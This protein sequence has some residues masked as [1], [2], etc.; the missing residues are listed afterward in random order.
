MFK[1]P[2]SLFIT[3]THPSDQKRKA[4]KRAVS[5]FVSKS[6]RP[7]S[8]KIVFEKSHYRPFLQ[9]QPSPSPPSAAADGV[10]K[11]SRP[12]VHRAHSENP[13]R[14][15]ALDGA[16]DLHSLSETTAQ[17]SPASS[18][19]GGSLF[20]PEEEKLVD[21]L[22]ARF[23]LALNTERSRYER[24]LLVALD[25]AECYNAV[26]AQAYYRIDGDGFGNPHWRA[27]Y[28]RGEAMKL[29]REKMELRR[30]ADYAIFTAVMLLSVEYAHTDYTAW[31]LH[32]KALER[33]VADKGGLQ[34]IEATLRDEMLRNEFFLQVLVK[35]RVQVCS[36]SGG[37]T[38]RVQDVQPVDD[39]VLAGLPV[40]FMALALRMAL[41][42]SAAHFIGGFLTY[43]A[44]VG[45][46]RQ[47][48][49]QY[50]SYELSAPGVSQDEMEKILNLVDARQSRYVEHQACLALLVYIFN[51]HNQEAPEA[52]YLSILDDAATEMITIKSSGP[53]GS[54]ACLFWSIATIGAAAAESPW[55]LDMPFMGHIIL[56]MAVG[57]EHTNE[58]RQMLRSYY[59]YGANE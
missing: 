49:P 40:V 29:L 36:W 31:L 45:R 57:D 32:K 21:T 30:D 54:R 4:N 5:S 50:R 24:F 18:L 2:D 7:T 13:K 19:D 51:L 23:G 12:A 20:S 28:H 15:P 42:S 22:T 16:L 1:K 11:L 52:Q 53:L 46:Y 39:A 25:H 33:M 37:T 43:L 47:L 58:L 14:L 26:L 41:S 3:Y 35:G 17:P 27:L 6:Y 55:R 8:R 10:S 56:K 34:N 44:S 59:L 9:S 38:V 48:P